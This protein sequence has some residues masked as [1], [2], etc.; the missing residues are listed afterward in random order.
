M[1]STRLDENGNRAEYF[2]YGETFSSSLSVPD[3]FGTYARDS[4]SG[5][6]YA[7]Q[8]YYTSTYGRFSRPDPHP[9]SA[10]LGS[11]GSWNR[12]AYVGGDPINRNDPRGLC[13][14]INAADDVENGGTSDPIIEACEESSGGGGGA[15]DPCDSVVA[16][17]GCGLTTIATV[18]GC[19]TPGL[20]F[21]NGMCDL[22]IYQS[23]FTF[24]SGIFN[25]VGDNLGGF[26]GLL[27]AVTAPYAVAA[28][29]TT[30]V[31]S[32][33]GFAAAVPAAA[34]AASPQGQEAA[35]SAANAA[36]D[37]G[38]TVYRV[39]GGD[40]GPFGQFW[41]TV[42]PTMAPNYANAAGLPPGNTAQ[43][44]TTGTINSMTGV[45]TGQAPGIGGNL[46]GI[47]EIVIP[48]SI[49][50]VSVVCVQPF[51]PHP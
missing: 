38:S 50:Q 21:I 8:R 34:A 17:S 2:P 25:Q 39:W 3:L 12:Y 42:N 27:T 37:V 15:A 30:A 4:G 16:T 41:T 48:T 22:P 43:W 11:P 24:I 26:D 46:G 14:V 33:P 49:C 31:T 10:K 36:V 35:A 23:P 5:L 29:G 45:T 18:T 1:G 44:L 28:A 40:S 9:G 32:L 6:D 20:Q 47:F 13:G 19:A 7:N 51:V